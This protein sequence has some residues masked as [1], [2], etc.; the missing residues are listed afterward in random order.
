MR[1]AIRER[2]NLRALRARWNHGY[3]VLMLCWFGWISIYLCRSVLPPVLPILIE[4]LELTHTQAG[5][6]ATAFLLGYIMIKIPVGPLA[7]RIG[8]KNILILSMVGYGVATML[9]IL[10]ATFLQLLILRFFVGLFQGIHLPVANTLL[11]ERF[12]TRQGR[13]IGFHESGPNV[14]NAMALPLSVTIASLWSWRWAFFLLSLPAFAMAFSTAFILK[15]DGGVE[16]PQIHPEGNPSGYHG[17][18]F[19]L[20]LLVSLALAH[21]VYNICLQTL[22][23]FAPTFLVESR[24]MSLATAGIISMIMPAAGFFAK[25]S[26]GFIAEKFGRR[27]AI[28]AATTLSGAFIAALAFFKGEYE[29]AII[30]VLIGLVLYSFSPTIYAYVTAMLPLHLKTTGLSLVTMTG[31]IVGALSAP[32]AGFLIDAHGY[33][34]ALFCVSSTA[35]FTTVIIYIS[36]AGVG[37]R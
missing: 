35:I 24:G 16:E 9:N 34:T 36:L 25:I 7:E 29:L 26:S 18:R 6:F 10:A 20:R 30:F 2:I 14:G 13:A 1:H 33:D 28:C 23:N 22:F 4:E 31:N 17:L 19:F 11:S 32:L 27:N 3:T 21:A 5:L 8:I 12:K 37:E 15:D